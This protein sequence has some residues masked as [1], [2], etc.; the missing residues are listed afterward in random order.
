MEFAIIMPLLVLLLIGIIESGWIFAQYLD[1]RHGARE[2]ARL[3]VVNYPEGTDAPVASPSDNLDALVVETCSRMSVASG[4]TLSFA[5]AGGE[6][7]PVTVAVEAPSDTLSGLLDW[8]FGSLTVTSTAV[9]HAEQ[10]AT[11]S[12]GAGDQS[13]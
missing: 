10:P 11:W 13:C 8:A 2:G 12:T 5:S 3:A 1:V 9:L 6:G 7:D 4:I